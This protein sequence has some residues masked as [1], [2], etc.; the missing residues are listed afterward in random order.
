M[1]AARHAAWNV[2]WSLVLFLL[3]MFLLLVVMSRPAYGGEPTDDDPRWLPSLTE[4][5]TEAVGEFR[6]GRPRSGAERFRALE[7]DVAFRGDVN[8]S[9]EEAW[10]VWSAL[11]AQA[12]RRA[13][14]A[15]LGWHA[16]NLPYETRSWKYLAMTTIHLQQGRLEAA[17]DTLGEAWSLDAN[18]P[19]VHYLGGLLHL[20]CADAGY[21]W[22][23]AI[24]PPRVMLT[25]QQPR[26]APWHQG[27]Y[28]LLAI[29][30]LERV[31]EMADL[32]RTEQPLLAT[33]AGMEVVL[34]PTVG[35]MLIAM[36]A[37][38]FRGDSH[39]LLANLFLEQ[40]QY[41]VAE[42]HL[43]RA[44]EVP[45]QVAFGYDELGEGYASEGRYLDAARAYAKAVRRGPSGTG[46]AEAVLRQLRNAVQDAWF[47]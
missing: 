32:L 18:N 43:D 21:E 26:G 11:M 13:S 24:G 5:W 19:I 46:S 45:G 12:D 2:V 35:D 39:H 23:D 30:E 28:T 20:E 44:L 10:Q 4:R 3:A 34:M 36:Q 1:F 25:S 17:S 27:I 14:D 47:R 16:V 31:V 29:T 7:R 37:Q 6:Q 42:H 9:Q 38:H 40:G 8:Q 33:N 15:L 22:F 41:D